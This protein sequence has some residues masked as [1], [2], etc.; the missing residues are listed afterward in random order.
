MFLFIL[1][2]ELKID[3]YTKQLT[4]LM[5]LFEYFKPEMEF[6]NDVKKHLEQFPYLHYSVREIEGVL[7]VS[8]GG[9]V[10]FK[11]IKG[12]IAPFTIEQV[13]EKPLKVKITG[14]KTISDFEQFK[15]KTIIGN[16][17]KI[18]IP[19]LKLESVLCKVDS[20]ATTSSIDVSYLHID[21]KNNKV[22][23]TPLRPKHEGY[24]DKKFTAPI[25]EEVRVQSSNGTSE[26]RVMIKLNIVIKGKKLETFF[27]LADRKEL[28][29]PILIGKDIL[30]N[31]FLIDT[32]IVNE[33]KA[34]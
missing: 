24:V 17:E 25:A 7:Y 34:E 2:E 27:S 14:K 30:S 18:D 33:R 6:N 15:G 16:T 8:F 29:Y 20:G 10:S 5:L 26:Y 31:N 1:F 32:S 13:Q 19:S 22:T 4:R 3:I 9:D 11:Y 28:D 21:K 23:F 12:V